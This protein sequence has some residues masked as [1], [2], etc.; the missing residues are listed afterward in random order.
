MPPSYIPS[1]L[2]GF[3]CP[4][5]LGVTKSFLCYILLTGA[6]AEPCQ[7]KEGE[8]VSSLV[9]IKAHKEHRVK[10]KKHG[11]RAVASFYF[12]LFGISSC[13]VAKAGC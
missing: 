5:H 1:P 4:S 8:G 9:W 10:K 6:L 12:V 3:S 7:I 11:N 2:G 13:Y